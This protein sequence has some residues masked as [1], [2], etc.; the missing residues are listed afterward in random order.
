MAQETRG[1]KFSG[2]ACSLGAI[3]IGLCQ[4]NA[5]KVF[6]IPKA[7]EVKA[8]IRPD[9]DDASTQDAGAARFAFAPHP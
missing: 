7:R 1:V 9:L 8:P 3:P 2:D 6:Q 5:Q 4:A